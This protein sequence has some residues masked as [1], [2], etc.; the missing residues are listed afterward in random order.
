MKT[1]LESP[2]VDRRPS[3]G[4]ELVEIMEMDTLPALGSVPLPPTVRFL[5]FL[6]LAGTVA[7]AVA[8]VFVPWQQS[9]A[10]DGRVVAFTPAERQQV[11]AAPVEGRLLKTFVIEGT[12]VKQGDPL[13]E[14]TDND[15]TILENLRRDQSAL[16]DRLK[17]A[18]ARVDSF[19]G[20]IMGLEGS[21]RNAL[22]S[23]ALRIQAAGERVAA[24]DR[25]IEAAESN[26]LTAQL[27]L[28]RTKTLAQKGL[29][30]TRDLE[31]AQNTFDRDTAEFA[32]AK[33]SLNEAKKNLEALE[34]ERLRIE[35]DF[36]S[37]IESARAALNSAQADVAN[38]RSAQ[39]QMQ[40]RINRQ[41][42]QDVVSP[43]DG[44]VFRVLA[45]PGSE[46]LKSGDPVVIIVPETEAQTVELWVKGNDM[47][48]IQ[49]GD[50]VRLQF[51]GWPAIQF[52]GWPSVAV[53]TFGGLVKL[54]DATDDGK[55][56]FRILVGPDPADEAW[57][58]SRLRQGVRAN[59]WVLLK[60][61]PLGF[62]LWRQFNGFPPNLDAPPPEEKGSGKK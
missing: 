34:A 20:Q 1:T 51:E 23:A 56:K 60:I 36:K 11:V 5:A 10:G 30:S 9:V 29:R 4:P 16:E 55:G 31:L 25:F 40:I 50:K 26:L 2:A 27:N 43:R 44:T 14:I 53:G 32:R 35:N 24:A 28:E 48:L 41:Q 21:R 52:V 22:E 39:A 46:L 13:F 12:R 15:P 62:E 58:K 38:I 6:L 18:E 7:L 19:R 59:G 42:T 57:P 61:V 3:K 33:N 17:A 47:P 54:V 37:S 8:L 49:Q 45:Q